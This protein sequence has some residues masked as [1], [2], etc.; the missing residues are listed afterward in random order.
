MMVY[1]KSKWNIKK[2]YMSFKAC[3]NWKWLIKKTRIDS[4]VGLEG[5]WVTIMYFICL[6]AH[7]TMQIIRSHDGIQ[8]SDLCMK[9]SVVRIPSWTGEYYTFCLL[10]AR[11]KVDF[12]KTSEIW[13]INNLTGVIYRRQREKSIWILFNLYCLV[14][15]QTIFAT[16]Y[17]LPSTKRPCRTRLF[18]SWF[19]ITHGSSSGTVWCHLCYPRYRFTW[20]LCWPHIIFSQRKEYLRQEIWIW[21][22]CEYYYS[23]N[24]H[25]FIIYSIRGRL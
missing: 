9:R 10:Y 25:G 1:L 16:W 2:P 11:K 6:Y 15:I 12:W 21:T 4:L 3:L 18:G 23:L 17:D 20:I 8:G 14:C 13:F 22:L 19:S 7:F 5:L 24:K